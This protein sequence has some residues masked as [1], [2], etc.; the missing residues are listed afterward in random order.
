[1]RGFF[2]DVLTWLGLAPRQQIYYIGGSDILPPPLKGAE[3]AQTLRMPSSDSL[4]IICGLW[5]TYPGDLRIP[6]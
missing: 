4:S 2:A 1:M 6:G 5:C 3:E